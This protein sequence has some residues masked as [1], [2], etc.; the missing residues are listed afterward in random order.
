MIVLFLCFII[1][2][3][4]R[5]LCF[6]VIT[7]RPKRNVRKIEINSLAVDLMIEVALLTCI[8]FRVGKINK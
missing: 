7:Y 3:R 6:G 8:A 4:R 5:T 1:T 2:F